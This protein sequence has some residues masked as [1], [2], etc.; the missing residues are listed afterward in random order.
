MPRSVGLGHGCNQGEVPVCALDGLQLV[1]EW[2]VLGSA[3]GIEQEE[4]VREPRGDGVQQ[5][6]AEGGDSDSA[7]DEDRRGGV[8][9]VKRRLTD[10]PSI[11]TSVPSGLVFRARLSA[12][13]R[14]R[15]VTMS[16][17]SLGALARE[18]LRVFPLASIACG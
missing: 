12:L 7:G 16:R 13:S 18:N 14:T 4:A 11:S 10:G 8:I 3:V 15:V 5:R 6:A 17:F 2:C 9:L 1:K